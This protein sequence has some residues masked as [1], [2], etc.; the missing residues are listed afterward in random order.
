MPTILRSTGRVLLMHWPLLLAWFL[1]GT[2][3]RYG[4]IELSGFA[5]AHWSVGGLL[6]L[7]LAVLARLISFVGMFLVVRDGLRELQSIAPLPESGRERRATFV[8]SLLAGI[9]P[10]FAVYAAWGMLRDDTEAYAMRAL[11]VHTGLGWQ[12]F[13]EA[14][15]NGTSVPEPAEQWSALDAGIGPWTLLIIAAAFALRWA[16]KRWQSGLPRAF[17]LVAVYLEAVWVFFFVWTVK[18]ITVAVG[19]WASH[20]A[21]VVWFEGLRDAIAERVAVLGAIWDGVAWLLGQ[22]GGVLLQPLAWLTVAGVIYGQAIA[23][24]K[25]R[26]AERYLAEN[27][28]GGRYVAGARARYAKVPEWTRKR[29]GDLGKEFTSRFQ[30][31]WRSV[32]LMWRAGPIPIATYVLLYTVVLA[33]EPLL[34]TAIIRLV[35]PHDLY[36][37]WIVADGLLF[38]LV[39]LIV[40]PVRIAVVASA[41]DATLGAL[42]RTEG[43]AA[44]AAE[45]DPDADPDAVSGSHA[46]A[47]QVSRDQDPSVEGSIGKRAND[48]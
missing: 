10:F 37:F 1:G 16:W 13:A 14:I 43:R 26:L 39:P 25:L 2:L 46:V 48:G 29:M 40:E 5:G 30:P 47:E 27:R 17:A 42:R 44:A 33:L 19:E 45:A 38:L 34:R 32:R 35:G 12:A 7:P 6:L 31:V 28:F 8:Q 36:S 11:D 22:A 24:E 41:Y 23:V 15:E 3:A 4:A 9:L 21:A 18:D 20:R